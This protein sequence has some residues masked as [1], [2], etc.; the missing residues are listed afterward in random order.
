MIEI[1]DYELSNFK[2][3]EINGLELLI[4]PIDWPDFTF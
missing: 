3:N 1:I 4:R 2:F